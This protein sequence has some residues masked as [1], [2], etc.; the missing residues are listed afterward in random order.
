MWRYLKRD[1]TWSWANAQQLKYKDCMKIS[2]SVKN[3][4]GLHVIVG[5]GLK[6]GVQ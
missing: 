4:I 2:S 5:Q 3:E 1:W 6:I